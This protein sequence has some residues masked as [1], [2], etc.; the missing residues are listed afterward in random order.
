MASYDYRCRE[1]DG[2]FTVERPMSAVAT[3]VRC[4]KGH[5]DVAR[6]WSPISISGRA[7]APAASGG[8]CGGNCGCR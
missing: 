5:E 2:L 6:V 1:C 7:A 8:C 4:P 3:A